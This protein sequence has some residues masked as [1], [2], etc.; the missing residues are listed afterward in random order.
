MLRG[1]SRFLLLFAYYLRYLNEATTN[2]KAV[3]VMDITDNSSL[4]GIREVRRVTSLE[5]CL[6]VCQRCVG[7]VHY[8]DNTCII[9][10]KLDRVVFSSFGATCCFAV[11]NQDEMEYEMEGPTNILYVWT[12]NPQTNLSYKVIPYDCQQTPFT[13][14]NLCKKE[15][16]HLASIHSQQEDSFISG[17]GIRSCHC[18]HI[19]LYS[20]ATRA[21]S[22]YWHDGTAV[23]YLNWKINEPHG[24]GPLCAYIWQ[25]NGWISGKCTDS[26][27]GCCAVCQKND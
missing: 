15:N 10:N 1:L 2:R 22:F 8:P 7:L 24:S 14:E 13:Y 4:M 6:N 25:T 16:G 21:D 26:G 23:D 5:N 18:K 3:T 11:E 12:R 19:G 17:L 20:M 9:F 27:S